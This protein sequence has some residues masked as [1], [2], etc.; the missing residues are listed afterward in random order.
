MGIGYVII[1]SKEETDEILNVINQQ[2]EKLG[3][4]VKYVKVR[5]GWYFCQ[6]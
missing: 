3:L 2:N 6:S 4:S 5:A 1:V